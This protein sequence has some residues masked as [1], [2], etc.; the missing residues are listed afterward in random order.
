M[1]AVQEAR[2][3]EVCEK[4]QQI[5]PLFIHSPNNSVFG[6]KTWCDFAFTEKQLMRVH[7]G[8]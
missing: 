6:G 2:F 7:W 5:V 4:K 3:F 1:K 8:K